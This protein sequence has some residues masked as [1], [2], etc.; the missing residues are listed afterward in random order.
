MSNENLNLSIAKYKKIGALNVL[1]F[2]L[3]FI[4]FLFHWRIHY[5]VAYPN[6]FFLDKFILA[7][8]FAMSGF[9]ILSGFLLYY[10]Y[11]GKDF[12]DFDYLKKFYLKRIFKILPPYYV[13]I[14]IMY[15]LYGL[16]LHQSVNWSV[17]L[18]SIIPIQAFCRIFSV[19][20]S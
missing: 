16:I 20:G 7:G 5:G 18:V 15:I 9:F 8:A 3:V 10:I 2:A 4:I 12:S 6:V 13:L 19:N 11:S 1:K 14:F 17:L